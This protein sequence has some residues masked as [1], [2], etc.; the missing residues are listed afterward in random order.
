MPKQKAGT[1]LKN[2]ELFL[3]RDIYYVIISLCINMLEIAKL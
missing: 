3:Y 1:I 2:W